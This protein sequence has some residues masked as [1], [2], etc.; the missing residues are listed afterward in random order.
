MIF[1]IRVQLTEQKRKTP[2]KK[3]FKIKSH[4]EKNN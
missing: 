4:L 1:L 2:F 3:V